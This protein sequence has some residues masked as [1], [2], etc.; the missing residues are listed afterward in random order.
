M[1]ACKVLAVG[2]MK[3]NISWAVAVKKAHAINIIQLD[4]AI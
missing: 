4:L 3:R 1:K 2:P